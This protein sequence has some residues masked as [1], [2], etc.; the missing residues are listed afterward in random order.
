MILGMPEAAASTPNDSPMS[1]VE[2]GGAKASNSVSRP[3]RNT[4]YIGHSKRDSKYI[5]YRDWK[6]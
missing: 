4:V 1:G 5:P 3:R 6:R 2:L